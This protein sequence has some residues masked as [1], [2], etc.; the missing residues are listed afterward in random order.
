MEHVDY[1]VDEVRL[2][3]GESVVSVLHYFDTKEFLYRAF[4]CDFQSCGLY[5]VYGVVYFLLAWADGIICVQDVDDAP[6]EEDA[7]VN[8]RLSE[9]NQLQ[10][11]YQV[12]VP[13][14]ASLLLSVHILFDSEELIIWVAAFQ[15]DSLGNVYEHFLFCRGLWLNEDEVKLRCVPIVHRGN[16]EE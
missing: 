9:T 2:S 4:D 8:F 6:V 14:A 3:H 1:L 7:T 12:L 5:L 15:G 13:D 16:D 10:F 11:T